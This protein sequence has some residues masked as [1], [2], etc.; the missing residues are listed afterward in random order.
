MRHACL[1]GLP[2]ARAGPVRVLARGHLPG[3]R[4]VDAGPQGRRSGL[5][6]DGGDA[7]AGTINRARIASRAQTTRHGPREVAATDEAFY[8][9]NLQL[10]VDCRTPVRHDGRPSSA[11]GS[12]SWSTRPSPTTST[13]TTTGGCCRSG[14]R[15]T[16]S[17]PGAA[18]RRRCAG[19]RPRGRGRGHGADAGAVG[20]RRRGR[21]R[22]DARAR[23]S[24]RRRGVGG[25]ARGAPA[26]RRRGRSC[27]RPCCGT[28]RTT[29]PTAPCP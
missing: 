26:D 9:V 22:R 12:S 18:P 29:S 1:G 15:T 5:R 17:D 21:T 8:F 25:D 6:L 4:P 3:I 11:R 24:V 13:S 20:R 2:A 10:A 23:A 27:G 19:R 14:C 7:A 16:C 28:C